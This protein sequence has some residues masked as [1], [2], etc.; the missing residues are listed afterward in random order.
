MFLNG[1][2]GNTLRS[3][4]KKK[5]FYRSVIMQVQ[6]LVSPKSEP[7]KSAMRASREA[8]VAADKGRTTEDHDASFKLEYVIKCL[9]I[10]F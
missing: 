8:V 6:R 2:N 7:E 1:K 5:P 9:D 3:R 4:C 10:I